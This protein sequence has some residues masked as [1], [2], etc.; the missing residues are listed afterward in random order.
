MRGMAMQIITKAGQAAGLPEGRVM[1]ASAA[2]NLTLARPRVEVSFSPQTYT[3]KGQKLGTER[4]GARQITKTELYETRLEVTAQIYADDAAWL[5]AFEYEFIAA[6]AE[7]SRNDVRGNWVKVRVSQSVFTSEEPTK[8]VG[9]SEI[10]I[11]GKVNTVV[12][13]AFTGRVTK[14]S[15]Q[16]L[17]SGT[18]D[19]KISMNR[20]E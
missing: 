11:F 10:K 14:D 19:L 18:P 16:P 8:R 7:G 2:D 13:L 1:D 12:D 4:I 9:T 17:V 20:K 3:Y 6:L 15:E 5:E